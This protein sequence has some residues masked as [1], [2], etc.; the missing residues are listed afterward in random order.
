MLTN[1]SIH[2]IFEYKQVQKCLPYLTILNEAYKYIFD[3]FYLFCKNSFRH[4]EGLAVDHDGYVYVADTGNHA[5]RMI[6]PS[7]TVTTIAGTGQPGYRDGHSSDGAT[8]SSPSGITVWRD[9]YHQSDAGRIVL[10]VADTGNHRIRIITGE[11]SI[12]EESREK[13]MHNVKIECF[14]GNCDKAPQAGYADGNKYQSRFDTPVGIA[15]SSSGHIYVTD[16][17]NHLIRMVNTGGDATTLAGKL[18]L[19]EV[20]S[21]GGRLE[22][23]PDPCLTGS[24]GHEDGDLAS[25][26][27]AFPTGVALSP[28]EK[29]LLV[30]NRHFLRSVDI[31]RQSV[32]T[33]A[34]ENRESE[35]DGQ[36]LEA[37]FNK[38]N[39]IIITSDGFAYIVDSSSCRIRR[40][41]APK[42]FVPTIKCTDNVA[43][44]FR[45]SGCS[46]YNAKIDQHG[47]KATPQSGNIH[48]NY[49]H[50]NWTHR[51][52]GEDFIGRGIKDCVGSPPTKVLDKVRWNESTLVIDDLE[53]N[54]R[55][56]PNDGSLIQ[57]ACPTTICDGV[58][59]VHGI[60]IPVEGSSS[61]YVLRYTTE[62][63]ICIAA[64]H[65]GLIMG[66]T[67]EK[68]IFDIKLHHPMIFEP[69][70]YF[71]YSVIKGEELLQSIPEARQYF[72]IQ[73][74]P[75]DLV[76]QTISGA[77]ATLRGKS[78]GYEDSVPAQEAKVSSL[79]FF[80]VF[81]SLV[82]NHAITSKS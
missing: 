64:A 53:V 59:F 61:D 3:S 57:V 36:G 49:L 47:L 51:E 17:N 4:P 45:P 28:D 55:E 29:S 15:V 70:I 25:A 9:W 22:G 26:K 52:L 43:N 60:K 32:T 5:I 66:V 41:A 76:I 21:E 56:D 80:L 44:I 73:L 30:T 54:V 78:C 50:R 14:S 33:L 35:R 19:A 48:Y 63:P 75:Q 40:A 13:E 16:T 67:E 1:I 31:H 58:D 2:N 8:L 34:G 77:P 11:M 20:N 46:S 82:S 79:F 42:L 74:S 62:S 68:V 23:C 12:K 39:D 72:S 38:P 6:S 7:G 37:S 10:F 27:F 81:L 71:R 65:A 69:S 18:V 24:L